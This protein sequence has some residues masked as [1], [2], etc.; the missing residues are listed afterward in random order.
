MR[1]LIVAGLLAAS[2]T[3]VAG[4]PAEP[5]I[6]EAIKALVPQANIDSIQD[7]PLPGFKEVVLEGQQV[8]YVSTDGK[9]L[10]AGSVWDIPGKRDL[11][12]VRRGTLRK[13]A[14]EAIGADK[15]IVFAAKEAKHTVTVFTDIDCGYCR[16]L[17]QQ[18]A[19]YN[20]AGI[21]IE[22]LFFPRSGPNTES[23]NQAVAVWCSA[24][25]NS[26]LTKAKA[27]EKLEGRS[28][29]NPIAE[30]FELGRKIGVAGTPAVIAAD[31]TQIGGYL[32]PDQMIAR[33]DQL[34]AEAKS[35]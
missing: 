17:H 1:R 7:A 30:E 5:K 13:A 28:C 23:F 6:R 15:R 31:G 20:N 19:E 24:D 2:Y 22:Y 8:L 14:L 32:A 21:S 3:V 26:A 11:T 29:P 9:Y 27:G 35:K 10:V 25:R 18:I 34:A 12:D 33:L 4:D 16:R